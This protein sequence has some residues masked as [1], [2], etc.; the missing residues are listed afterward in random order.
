MERNAIPLGTALVEAE[1]KLDALFASKTITP[2]LLSESLNEIGALQAQVRAV[3][4][5]AHL[6]QVAI[7]TFEQ[8]AR[9]AQ[10]RGYMAEAPM[11][12]TAHSPTD[13]HAH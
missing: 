11:Q 5:N 8:S 7:L 13:Q 9:Y 3:H 12:S 2:A 6:E 10:L 4:L 1:R